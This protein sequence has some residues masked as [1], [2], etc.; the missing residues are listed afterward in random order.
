[1]SIK[2]TKIPATIQKTI[3]HV[4][5]K[6]PQIASIVADVTHH[7][8]SVL[9]VGGAVR[10]LF[11]KRPIK[12]IDIEVHTLSSDTLEQILRAYGP[13][14]YVGKAYGVF[15]VHPLVIDWS[16]PRT[17]KPGRKPEVHI[18]PSMSVAQAFRRRD[19]TI[20]AMGI[21]LVT[22]ELIDPFNGFS[23]LKN[24]ILRATDEKLFAEDP[25]RFYRVMQFI[26][27]F[28]MAPEESLNHLCK[29]IDLTGVSVERIEQEFEKL[30]L[31]SVRPALGI[32]WL[33]S[34]GRL[35]DVLPELADVADTPQD[36][37]W[38]PE[39]TV[40]EHTMQT[41][42][43]A[44]HIECN[45]QTKKLILLYAALC[46]DLG[47]ALATYEVGERIKSTGHAELGVPLV[48]KLL[49]RITKKKDIIDAVV[50]LVKYHM[51]PVQ[52]IQGKAKPSAYK[53][54]AAKLA[55]HVT[56][57]MLADLAL[58]D[59]LARNPRGEKPRRGTV[60]AVTKFLKKAH[61][62]EVLEHKEAPVLL[63]R[64]LLDVVSPGP[65]LGK[66]VAQAYEIQLEEG[67][68]DK[69]VLRERVLMDKN[70]K[71]R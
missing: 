55:P 65:K 30:L 8:G 10:D 70:S 19:L 28:E 3:M 14:D 34:I 35:Q 1:M 62:F 61:E 33:A 67:I 17:D 60:H 50:A 13:V 4:L 64:D 48:K 7:G 37:L 46:H 22:Y 12:D 42:D 39:G 68:H 29:K 57:Q 52:F 15:R 59:K 43:A 66:L 49:A 32:R 21:N 11:L 16:L 6:Y 36:P 54:L 2:I 31:Q 63:G 41:I 20:N 38:H 71:K 53:R 9:L 23:D 45:D 24:K 25:L 56:L 69:Q 27:R 58:A 18:D 47:K 40:F 26:S 51:A 5:S 44:A